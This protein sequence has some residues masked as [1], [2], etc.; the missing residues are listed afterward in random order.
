MGELWF[1]PFQFIS[2]LKYMLSGMVGIFIVIGL[3]V[4]SVFLLNYYTSPRQDKDDEE[5]K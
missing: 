5:Q 3:I 1:K 4:L 2:N